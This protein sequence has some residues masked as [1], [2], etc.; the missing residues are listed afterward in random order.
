MEAWGRR[1]WE[2]HNKKAGVRNTVHFKHT[3]RLKNPL[4][5]LWTE[6]VKCQLARLVTDTRAESTHRT[7]EG[8]SLMFNFMGLQPG[9][10]M[11]PCLKHQTNQPNDQTK[12]QIVSTLVVLG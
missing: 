1:N 2:R 11:S 5:K 3:G 7:R 8:G 6:K 10:T 9:Y 12:K 4:G